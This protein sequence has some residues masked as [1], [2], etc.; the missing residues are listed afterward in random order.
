MY[1]AETMVWRSTHRGVTPRGVTPPTVLRALSLS[2]IEARITLLNSACELVDRESDPHELQLKTV[3]LT[4]P[5]DL[6]S[7]RAPCDP[8][9]TIG[10]PI[11][12]GNSVIPNILIIERRKLFHHAQTRCCELA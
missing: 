12:I 7:P 10:W 4:A 6:L 9:Q 8:I 1:S 2:S 5:R 11:A 3:T